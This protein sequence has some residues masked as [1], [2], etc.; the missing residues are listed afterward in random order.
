MSFYNVVIINLIIQ[1]PIIRQPFKLISGVAFLVT[2]TLLEDVQ[3][4]SRVCRYHLRTQIF[5]IL[6]Y[7][8]KMLPA[9]EYRISLFKER[10]SA[11]LK[12]FSLPTDVTG[13]I[14]IGHLYLN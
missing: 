5:L 1:P 10:V 9:L 11:L 13:I 3:E 7:D 4:V 14:F 12:I 6:K 2:L 8:K